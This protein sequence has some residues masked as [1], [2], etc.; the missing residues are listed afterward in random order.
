MAR[1]RPVTQGFKDV[2]NRT[3]SSR[4]HGRIFIHS[5]RNLSPDFEKVNNLAKRNFNIDCPPE[6]YFT[7]RLG[8]ITGIAQFGSMLESVESR[9]KQPGKHCWPIRWAF[10][11]EPSQRVRGAVGIW[12]VT[13]ERMTIELMNEAKVCR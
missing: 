4:F 8:R 9:W 2:E 11:C 5:G 12:T 1:L 13:D 3:W 10:P 6:E 7:A